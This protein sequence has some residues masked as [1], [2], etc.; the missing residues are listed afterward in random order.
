MCRLICNLPELSIRIFQSACFLLL[1]YRYVFRITDPD[2]FC[3]R[4]AYPTEHYPCCFS[5]TIP[6]KIL[7]HHKAYEL[8]TLRSSLNL[9]YPTEHYPCCFS[10]TIPYKILH[11]HKASGF[12]TLHFSFFTYT[13]IAYTTK[14]ILWIHNNDRIHKIFVLN[15]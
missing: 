12:F 3:C 10:T 5:T 6:Y 7:Y 13:C 4:I 1:I 11:H 2:T 8:F 14:N 9:S 15:L